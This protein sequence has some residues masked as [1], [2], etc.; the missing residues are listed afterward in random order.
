[1]RVG[2]ER[3]LFRMLTSCKRLFTRRKKR[4]LITPLTLSIL[5]V[6]IL[7]MAVV[8]V[9][10]ASLPT[11][12]LNPPKVVDPALV[13][14]KN[15]T[16]DLRVDNVEKLWGYQFELSFNPAVL[17]GVSVQNGPFLESAGGTTVVVPGPGFDNEAGTLG[18]FAAALF[19]L[20]NFP[21]G[22][23]T[24][25]TITF[26]VFGYGVSPIAL[27]LETGLAN[28]TGGWII[29]K[30]PIYPKEYHPECFFDSY[31]S[32]GPVYVDPPRVR[33][34]KVGES[35][36]VNVSAGYVEDLY[37]WEFCL[38][39]S[40]PTLLNVTSVVEG[41]FLS[42]PLYREI[43]NDEGY[44]YANCTRTGTT[45]VTGSGTLAQITFL[46]E[47]NGKSALHLYR[48]RLRNSAGSDITVE[49]VDGWFINEKHSLTIDSS[50]VSGIEF[51]LDS[52]PYTTPFSADLEDN[53]YTVVMPSK[54]TILE[55][56]YRFV[57]WADGPTDSTR[58]INLTTD[59]SLTANYA[60][61]PVLNIDTNKRYKTIQEA[62]N[63]Y[64]TLDG[65]TIL[66]DAGTYYENVV[67][68]KS[69]RL[70]GEDRSTTIIEGSGVF[71]KIIYVTADNVNI[72]GFTMQNSTYF[73]IHLEGCSNHNISGNTILNCGFNGI[74]VFSSDNNTISNNILIKN[75]F[76]GIYL[77][78]SNG[79]TI[80]G[81][82]IDSNGL[83]LEWD[84]SNSNAVVA[85][86]ISNNAECG[87]LLY[88]SS[89][90]NTISKNV[91]IKNGYSG[92]Y[93]EESN[94]N[95]IYGN[96]ID[97]TFGEG[98]YLNNANSNAVVAN[99]ISN[100]EKLGVYVGGGDDNIFYH[101]NFLD[102]ALAE[103][104]KN[105]TGV[106]E[107]SNWDSPEDAY[108]SDNFYTNAT[109][110]G[111][112]ATYYGYGFTEI[113]YSGIPAKITKVEVGIEGFCSSGDDYLQVQVSWDNGASWTSLF[114]YTPP[115]SDSNTTVYEDVTDDRTWTWDE[116]S[117][118]NFLVRMFKGTLDE[119][120]VIYTDWLP[121]KVTSVLQAYDYGENFWDNGY[122]SGGNYWS[123]YTDVDLYSG[124]YQNETG[125][126]GIWDHP[127]IIDQS[128]N[129]NYPLVYQWIG[130]VVIDNAVTSDDRCDV[131]TEQTISF[132]AK[133][134]LTGSDVTTGFIY[135]NETSF[136]LNGTGWI[137][138]N[139]PAYDTV[140]KR[141]WTITGVS[142]RYVT[143][144]L[145]IIDDPYIIW[146][147]VNLTLRVTD[148]RINVGDTASITWTG[149]YEYDNSD[150]TGTVEA[151]NDTRTKDVVG[152]YWYK[153]TQISDPTHGLTKFESNPLYC[154]FDKVTVTL[155]VN[156]D[157]IDVDSPAP[158]TKSG[159][160]QYNNAI[161]DGTITLNDTLTKST[162]GKYGYKT[163]EI[164]GDS[165]GITKF[166]TNAVSVVFDKVRITLNVDDNRIDIGTSATITWTG[167]YKYDLTT[168]T[169]TLTLNDTLTKNAVGKYWYT[170]ASI[171]DPTHGLTKF[172]CEPV[173]CVFDRV[174]IVILVT[175]DR[176]N[177]GD[178]A[179]LSWTGTYE[180]DGS[181]F[182][183][184][185]V[186]NDTLTKE[187]VG[188]YWYTTKSIIEEKHGL[189]EFAS[190]SVPV[191]FDK[192]TITLAVNDDRIDVSSPAS[193]TKSGIYQYN[194][195]IYDGTITLNDT[196]TKTVVGK[197]G[198]T[199]QG[200]SGDSH[201]IT[202]FASNSVSVVFDKVHITL[203]VDDNR[204][205][206]G[207]SAAV[208]GTGYYEYDSTAFTGTLSFN[209]TLTKDT[210]GKY[211]Y[212]V[213][214]ISDPTHGL[215]VF[216]SNSVYC[217]FDRVQIV[218][219]VADDRINVGDTAALSWTGTYA[220]DGS[221]FEGSIAYNDTLSKTVVGKYGYDVASISDLTHGL[222]AFTTNEVD[223]IFD[224]VTVTLSTNDDTVE[225]G[226]TASITWTA[227]YQ[228]D[229]VSFDGAITLNDTLTKSTAGTYY[230]TTESISDDTYG[231]T[232]FESNTLAV[233]FFVSSA[234][235]PLWIIGVAAAVLIGVVLAA[236][237][238]F[239]RRGKG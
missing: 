24:L 20:K 97:Q 192:V 238:F 131:G 90:Y 87:V 231:I 160:Y 96:T 210:V 154:I 159:I 17:H 51:T 83:G 15:F 46:V 133:W 92:M 114:S 158:I 173:Y 77:K 94:Y 62:I 145:K 174:Q 105:A 202:V 119:E 200:I 151:Y 163:Q 144:Y 26:E 206:I 217:V 27:G 5:L 171:S 218:I 79:S 39:W 220:Y 189:K 8:E 193:I 191:I 19:P 113:I 71:D 110:E 235:F 139:T 219:S 33:G 7:S 176:I 120:N 59:L 222:T 74:F 84:G 47:G 44:I 70:V 209:D 213:A 126:D 195:A 201:G 53:C 99:T 45:G 156:D 88:S 6:L 228:Y 188:K 177:V 48:L 111:A 127:Y 30:N 25:A 216:E 11:V 190:N 43:H 185:V 68:N 40:D 49:T 1:M 41:D 167:Y 169:G 224:K 170:V 132:H 89:C 52:T 134:E 64:E 187:I 130:H 82:T 143:T 138:F 141:L 196:L 178:T 148:N 165:Y 16:I 157:W 86:T 42:Q 155:V 199:T 61:M 21:T 146:D 109:V 211:G 23:G 38:N 54:Q 75:R 239:M 117:D 226:S 22:S 197:Y 175:D 183:G 80:Y 69:L 116:L 121:V 107:S 67:L 180:Y 118:S 102:N 186:Y 103:T 108:T 29:T 37:S 150:F 181:T 32:N 166:E 91:L 227:V 12:S 76:S 223:V 128:N 60:Y 104:L 136:P 208:T 95:T 122:P 50:P 207:T 162:V 65:H 152:K 56:T 78:S 221:L 142:A 100:S 164:S 73:G 115:I 35:F 14:P 234:A 215:T 81:N 13:P 58:V 18:L 112:N 184:E 137:S 9:S 161:Y 203:N 198:Y 214:S 101:N 28:R 153:V 123:D 232:V 106:W 204:I 3:V 4:L 57:N 179:A 147:K 93:L 225:V 124:S 85:N 72:S 140:G 31:F 172:E 237:V 135:A 212:T 125:S 236:V 229:G 182:N 63:D 34:V 230:Y 66:V 129:D 36:T 149:I 2:G 55:K 98:I 168:F 10:P 194:N 233:N 205:D